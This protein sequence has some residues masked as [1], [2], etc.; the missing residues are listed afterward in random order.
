M[1]VHKKGQSCQP[2][3]VVSKPTS[4]PNSW[5]N[6]DSKKFVTTT[7]WKVFLGQLPNQEHGK[8]GT[9]ITWAFKLYHNLQAGDT[10]DAS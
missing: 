7:T 5:L 1:V 8:H 9:K 3:Y 10:Q 6:Y 2:L 4:K